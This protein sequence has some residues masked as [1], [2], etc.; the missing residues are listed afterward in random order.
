MTG[1]TEAGYRGQ[2]A[3]PLMHATCG[4]VTI[5]AVAKRQAADIKRGPSASGIQPS[6]F[7]LVVGQFA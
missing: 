4:I 3:S 7:D 2:L 1:L 5:G 6:T